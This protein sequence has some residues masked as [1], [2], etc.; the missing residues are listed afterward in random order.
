ME[1]KKQSECVDVDDFDINKLQFPPIDFAK[2]FG[3]YKQH[4]VLPSYDGG[5]VYYRTGEIKLTYFGVLNAEFFKEDADI[6]QRAKIDIPIDPEQPNCVKLGEMISSIY[7]KVVA[8]KD[9]IFGKNASKYE[10][11]NPVKVPSDDEN[12]SNGGA[13]KKKP[14]INMSRVT[15]KFPLTFPDKKLDLV[16]YDATGKKIRKLKI[17]EMK[18]IYESVRWQSTIKLGFTIKKLWAADKPANGS[19][20][21]MAGIMLECA[22]IVVTEAPTNGDNVKKQLREG[23][24]FG[25]DDGKEIVE[26]NSDDEEEN[27]K[28]KS[29]KSKK[30][31]SNGDSDNEKPNKKQP[32]KKS[33]KGSDDDDDKPK[34]NSKKPSKDSD[35][36]DDKPKKNSNKDSDDDDDEDNKL[37]KNSGKDSDD[38]DEDDKPK[39]SKKSNKSNKDS[40]DEYENEKPKKN[41][42]KDEDDKN[43]KKSNEDSDDEDEAKKN[44]KKFSKDSDDEAEDEKPKKPKKSNKD[45]D[46]EAEDEDEKPKKSNKPSK[47]SDD[48]TEDEKPNKKSSKNSDD[49]A[50][51]KKNKKKP[52]KKEESDEESD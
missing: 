3:T 38:E 12:D 31:E 8:E 28:K 47:D 21:K 7:D 22:Q 18:D 24:A 44:K 33:S 14:K 30:V 5:R 10:I 9:T 4:V 15:F 20:T 6:G 11:T 2:S 52:A 51:D 1:G 17:K 43:K 41:S 35:D 25:R 46:D 39:K 40:D 42:N 32:K 48:E 26:A 23:Y 13:E 49:E 45:S 34:K 50:E 27:P 37:K 36:E 29:S 19:K 16:V